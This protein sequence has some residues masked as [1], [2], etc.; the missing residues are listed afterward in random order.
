M[1]RIASLLILLLILSACGTKKQLTNTEYTAIAERRDYLPQKR[2]FRGA[3]IPNAWRDE[4]QGKSTAYIQGRLVERLDLLKSLGFNAVIFQIRSEADAWYYSPYE[5]WSRTLTGRQGQAP[6]PLW[7]PLAFMVA[8]CH[9]RDMELHA[10]I[11]PY[12]AA[13]NVANGTRALSPKHP[14]HSHPEWF[15]RYGRQLYFNPALPEVTQY[16]CQVVD[17]IVERYDIDA[18]HLDD[19]FYP[20]PIAGEALPDRPEFERNP[21]G[22]TDI[23]EWRRDN[24]NRLISLLHATIKARKPYVQFGISP[25]GIYRNQKSAPMGSQTNGL[26][27]YD[28]LYADVLLWDAM[29]WVDYIVPQ[30]YW[31]IGHKAAD[32]TELARWWGQNIGLAHYYIGQDVKRTQDRNQLHAK[33]NIANETAR[34]VVMWPADELFKNYKEI[35]RQLINNYW[36]KP[37]LIPPTNYPQGI[38]PFEEPE[39]ETSVV[40][41]QGVATLYW[42]PDLPYPKGMETKYFVVYIHKRGEKLSKATSQENLLAITQNPFYPLPRIDGRQKVAFTITRINRYNH[43]ILVAHNVKAKI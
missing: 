11:N 21:K 12:R 41:H 30:I 40:T 32:Y 28:D 7:D 43:E 31:E 19:Y 9:K 14:Y 22:F 35:N 33:F 37:A 38:R 42:E 1:K 10:W 4:F 15:F 5:P 6:S 16:L 25:F 2:E 20:Y 23:R 26:Q 8:E 36:L 13:T 3:W 18:I 29:G 17:D 34:G 24:V 27:N 39:R